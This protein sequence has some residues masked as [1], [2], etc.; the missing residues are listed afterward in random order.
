MKEHRKNKAVSLSSLTVV[1]V[2]VAVAAVLAVCITIFA[3]VYSRALLKDA[4]VSSNQA[5]EQSVILVD[6]YLNSMKQKLNLIYEA[7]SDPDN[8]KD[9]Y[10]KISAVTRIQTDIYAVT[11]YGKN[12][13]IISCTGSGGKLKKNI[14]KDASFD[15]QLYQKTNGYILSS[16]HIETLF[17]NEYPWVVTLAVKT[18]EPIFKNGEY[19]AIDFNFSEIAK[20]I[21][22][23]GVGRQGYCYIIDSSGNIVY[24]PQQQLI[25]SGIKTENSE[26][27]NGMSDGKKT[28]DNAIYTVKTADGG[29]W[30]VVSVTYT[31]DMKSERRLQIAS[32]VAIVF[33]IGAS[34][35][36]S[37][38][39]VYSK[40]V[41]KPVKSIIR[42]IKRFEKETD[43]FE[44]SGGNETVRELRVISDTFG[45]MT[46]Q[47]KQLMEQV[48]REENELRKTELKALQAQ[49]NPHFLY[50]TLDSIQW[51]CERGKTEDA[52][53]MVSALARLFRISISK[54]RELITIKEELSHAENY[55]VI[56]SYRYKDRFT[57]SFD[58][59]ETLY[60]CLCNKITIQPLIE[61][62]IYHGIDP[63][64]D[65]GEIKISVKTAQDDKNDILITVSDNGV[66]MTAEQCNALL[67][68]ERSDSSGIGVKNVN[69]RLKIYF[70]DR[71]GLTVH[72]ELDIGTS[73]I[74]RI[75][76]KEGTENENP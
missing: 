4:E 69:D 28:D 34:V 59:D 51:M 23:I 12:G 27:F 46:G 52:A 9:M 38:F 37:V 65:E 36:L 8:S 26:Q 39:A 62:S 70:G 47:I 3:T 61:N 7:V 2:T 43:S 60:N 10:D 44:F 19:I 40:I 21:S 6:N 35:L 75:P 56:Q 57:Y 66:G 73:V 42:E 30:R 15:K 31:D 24:H 55:L 54:G 32:A 48:R 22:S 20:Y 49:I 64:V 72:S 53:K 41:N 45:H 1:S 18:A 11:V 67:K 68:K 16:P 33:L 58:V 5:A 25:F 63:L 29:K 76:R 17:E 50:N 13:E 74:V 71:Y 14:Y